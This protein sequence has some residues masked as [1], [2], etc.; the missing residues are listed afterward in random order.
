MKNK[1]IS[2]KAKGLTIKMYVRRTTK[3][4]KVYTNYQ[5]ADYSS[6]KRKFRS[7]AEESEARDKA[8]EL[9]N[10]MAAG[11]GDL[12]SFSD[13]KR[14]IQNALDEAKVAGLPIDE[15]VRL[16]RQA[17][18]IIP[19]GEILDACRFWKSRRPSRPFTP[20]TLREVT[21][22]YLSRQQRLSERRKRT[23]K[24]Y[25]DQLCE[26][27]GDRN[28]NEVDTIEIKDFADG[29]CWSHKTHNEALNAYGLLWKEAQLRNWVP[30]GCNPVT[31][32]K[33]LKLF[34]G[35][36]GI[37][38]PEQVRAMLSRVKEDMVP[39]LSIWCFAGCR[40]EEVARLRW[41]QIRRALKTGVLEISNEVGQKTGARCVP[42][43]PNLV[44]WLSWFLRRN[45]DID[46]PVLPMSRQG[47]RRL[48]DIQKR[49]A[50]QSK[51]EWV[52]NGPRHSYISYRSKLAPS[53][54]DVADEAGNSPAKIERHYRRKGVT[55][56]SA[57]EF[58]PSCRRPNVR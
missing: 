52:P 5:F 37:F 48:D 25:Y 42:L 10:A 45:S 39:F 8:L 20:K 41:T 2:V 17:G 49:I 47:N 11:E 44:A 50:T 54:T 7:F 15:A 29:K 38:E 31:G 32:I 4:G 19:I 22:D 1:A 6:G 35:S 28:M 55:I 9:C 30:A 56:E 46:G 34:P 58:L 33:R 16:V 18:E 14:P 51:I 57:K 40:K 3:N 27:L 13:I 43:Q 23:L 21:A 12:I 36:I 53:I 24:C 26:K